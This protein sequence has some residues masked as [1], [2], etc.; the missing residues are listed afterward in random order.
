MESQERL[1]T[2]YFWL[3]QKGNVKAL[4]HTWNKK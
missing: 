1:L 2:L 4:L 3:T